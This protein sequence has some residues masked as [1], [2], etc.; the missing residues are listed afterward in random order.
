MVNAARG[1]S[2][3][4]N[5]KPSSAHVS[6]QAP[7]VAAKPSAAVPTCVVLSLLRLRAHPYCTYVAG[8]GAEGGADGG[9]GGGDLGGNGDGGIAGGG[10]SRG[11]MLGGAAGG[12]ALQTGR[13][14]GE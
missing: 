4:K 6:R 12:G 2:R 13:I 10:G 7:S 9:G 8:G 1:Q 5:A 3:P 11:G 14:S